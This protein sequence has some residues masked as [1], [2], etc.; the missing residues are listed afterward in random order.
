MC[1]YHCHEFVADDGHAGSKKKL[2]NTWCQPTIDCSTE[3]DLTLHIVN[4]YVCFVIVGYLPHRTRFVGCLKV[5]H[6]NS[7]AFYDF[8]L[9]L[10]FIS[11]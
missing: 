10:M 9:F 11:S 6:K 3:H 1:C 7:H 5:V 8:L 4:S 2:L